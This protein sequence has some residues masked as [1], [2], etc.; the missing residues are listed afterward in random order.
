M[1]KPILPLT[2]N[3]SE[4]VQ[5]FIQ[6]PQLLQDLADACGSPLNIVFPQAVSA[7]IR[8]FREVY[9]KHAIAGRIYYAHKPN[10]SEAL[11][12]QVAIEAIYVDIASERELHS[13]LRAGFVGAKIQATGPKNRDFLTLALQHSVLISVD[14]FQELQSIQKLIATLKI[15]HA[16]I[17]VRLCGFVGMSK[18]SRFGVPISDLET[19]LSFI[20]AHQSTLKLKGFSFHL[21][22]A[23]LEEKV[24]ALVDTLNC[25]KLAHKKG[26]KLSIVNIG[27]G[28]KV[29]YLKHKGE[30]DEYVSALQQSVLG[31]RE[32]LSWQNSGLGYRSEHGVLKGG[33]SFYQY[34]NEIAGPDYLNRL[35]SFKPDSFDGQTVAQV[36][37]DN[38]L[39]LYIE[40]GRALLD[41]AG[42]TIAKVNFV[43][44]SPKGEVLVGLDMN[45]SNLDSLNQ[46]MMVDPVVVSNGGEQSASK[47]PIGVYFIGN[48][49]LESDFIYKHKTF[50]HAMPQADDLVIFTNTAAYNMDFTESRT[51]QQR[52]ATKLA[53]VEQNNTFKW[54]MDE[55]YRP[56][57]YPYDL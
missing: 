31:E 5:R 55:K 38:L 17:L 10:K 39:E 6:S 14:N 41:Q 48:L 54:Y 43:K 40:P 42:I 56:V 2:P 46:E 27:G 8:R 21:D 44:Q 50:V 15:E 25:I 3:I 12:R 52:I 7:N 26:L 1:N 28:F 19:V 9:D 51:L 35:L 13:A 30:W 47:S 32:S 20:S 22:T 29:N 53:V 24:I 57:A 36:L 45:R 34:F 33:P 18:E 23:S 49:C 4:R 16:N 11:V 37:S